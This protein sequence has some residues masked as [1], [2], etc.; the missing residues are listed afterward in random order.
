MTLIAGIISR[1]S[2]HPVPVSVCDTLKRLISRNPSDE[3]D[4]FQTTS[5]FFVKTDI[6]A[7]GKPGFKTDDSGALTLVA[8]EPLISFDVEGARRSREEDLE[9]IH[10]ECA[11][12]NRDIFKKAEGTF[13]AA[14]YQPVSGTLTL[15]ADKLCLRPLYYWFNEEYVIFAS[16]LRILEGIDEIPKTMDLRAVTEIAALGYPLGDRTPYSDIF[17]LEAAE[18]VTFDGRHISRQH[19]WNWDEIEISSDSEE[20]LLAALY[21]S[22]TDAVARRIGSDRT[23]VAYLSGGLDSRCVA[24]ALHTRNVR[25][26]T[27]NFARPNTQDQIFGLDFARKINAVH[28]EVPKDAGNLVPDYSAL[29]AE[30]WGSSKH[31]EKFPAEHPAL[32]WNGEGGSVALGHVHLNEK[33]VEMMR[34]GNVDAAI[35]EY[36]E[37]ESV[38]VSPKLFQPEIYA[39]LSEVI[40]NGIR[41]EISKLKCADPARNFY[42]YLMLNDQ[43]RKLAAHFENIDLHR[44]ELQSP[45]LDGAF[46]TSI[47]AVPL[48]WCLRHKF[49]VKWLALFDPAVT[50]VPWQAYPGHQ[51]CP[52]PIPDGLAYQWAAEYQTAERKTR[53][54]EVMKTASKLLRAKDFPARI[55]NKRNLRLVTLIHA[56]GWRDYDY[57]IEAADIYHKFCEKCGGEYTLPQ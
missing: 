40:R 7:Y 1:N 56:T 17:L 6:G 49:Y 20:D 39:R 34:A 23:T 43:R 22:F 37:R 29:M 33:I 9:L 12:G 30:A 13:C 19:Y 53:K 54:R 35:S 46:L 55:L 45:F 32:I 26:H 51:P 11:S 50:S 48:D 38:Y 36:T 4:V 8:G 18:T 25:V 52:L 5:G 27:F 42:F 24:A 2:N 57:I 21:R 44:L 41:E 15:I 31:R 10:R 3:V 28:E 14:H 47:A 16:A